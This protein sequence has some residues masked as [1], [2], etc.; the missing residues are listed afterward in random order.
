[1][2]H[3]PLLLLAFV[4]LG[5]AGNSEPGKCDGQTRP[6]AEQ[7]KGQPSKLEKVRQERLRLAKEGYALIFKSSLGQDDWRRWSVR[8]LDA[9][10]DLHKAKDKRIA[11]YEGHLSRMKALYDLDPPELR[12]ERKRA[13]GDVTAEYFLAEAEA[14]LEKAKSE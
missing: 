11:S 14:W 13:L 9:E 12:K 3:F 6:V 2:R 7:G 4:F 5:F 1:M 8:V 10:L